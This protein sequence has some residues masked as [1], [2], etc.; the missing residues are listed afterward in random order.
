M[1]PRE[2]MEKT[3]GSIET[4]RNAITFGENLGKA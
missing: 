4:P 2:N 3:L 1:R